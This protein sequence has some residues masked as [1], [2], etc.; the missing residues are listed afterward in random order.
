MMRLL[1]L[2][3]LA[4]PLL[5]DMNV[6]AQE[7]KKPLRPSL[8][9]KRAPKGTP[10][11]VFCLRRGA[12]DPHWYANFSHLA[13]GPEHRLYQDGGALCKYDA[14]TG[15]VSILMDDPEGS[16]RDPVVHFDGRKILFSYRKGGQP[17][18]NLYEIDVDGKN[19]KQITKGDFDDIEPCYLPDDRIMFVSSRCKRWVNCWLSRVAVIYRCHA[20][21]SNIEQISANIEHDNT[22]ALLPNGQILYTRWEYID[23]SQVD[24]HHLWVMNPDGTRQTVFMGNQTES[25]PG[26]CLL[27]DA[28]PIP[29]SNKIMTINSWGHG[30][31]EHGGNL[32]LIDPQGGPDQ[33]N[34]IIRFDDGYEP[35]W[36][37]DPFPYT[38]KDFVIST[39][40]QILRGSL[41]EDPFVVLCEAPETHKDFLVFEPRPIVKTP[42][43]P[44]IPDMVDNAKSTGDM[45]LFNVYEGR[46]MEGVQKGEVK[47]LLVLESLPKPINFTGGNEPLSY[48]GTFTLEGIV[49][50]VPVEEDGS[51][52]MKLPKDRSFFF[53]ALDE[54]LS[55]IQRMQS[56]T[57]VRG[58]ELISCIGCHEHRSSTPTLSPAGHTPLAA[59]KPPVEP[60]PVEGIPHVIDFPRD[61]QPIL[62]KHCIECHNGETRSGGRDLT[63]DDGPVYSMGYFS[64]VGGLQVSDGA[65]SWI[66]TPGARVIGDVNSKLIEKV[67]KHHHDV[68]LSPEEIKL[69]RFWINAGANYP[70]TYAALGSGQIARRY[71][72]GED[73]TITQD[74]R[75]AK[76][77]ETIKE[78]CTSCHP[79]LQP[80]ICDE[81]PLSFWRAR[82]DLH[83][84]G[85]KPDGYL[86]EIKFVRH[87]I[88]NLSRPENS[89]LLKA[90]LAKEAGGYGICSTPDGKPVL[91]SKDDP[92]YGILLDAVTAAKENLDNIGRFS[93]PGFVP[94]P[95][96]TRELKGYGILDPNQ[97]DTEPYDTYKADQN[98]WK[99]LW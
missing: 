48:S 17:Y 23:R 77:A 87:N 38:E 56:F 58:G 82:G 36:F 47:H 30:H 7:E 95:A 85:A 62:D 92:R 60:I 73:R 84:S 43:P 70:G 98:Y 24:F 75:V 1:S 19:L 53:V 33:K 8:V 11:L 27:I 50:L 49:G 57:S 21:G 61:I 3:F 55:S 54:N 81:G 4:L 79:S 15:K 35:G 18:Y 59:R 52:Y 78:S 14:Q 80:T 67:I 91:A 28:R 74:P 40:N 6:S 44:V 25:V 69:L 94:D 51:A 39:S 83:A 86:K 12:L 72:N 45:L 71:A 65:D 99:S 29:G 16:F 31:P 88:Y 68:T 64:L 37:H 13:A 76:A 89:S 90:P 5:G 10:D 20:D 26:A 22:P 93:R 46:N 96:Y 97:S 34:N 9:G 42:R 2:A 66:K 41:N 63:A 32:A